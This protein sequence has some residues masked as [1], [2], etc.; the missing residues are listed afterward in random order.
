MA[1]DLCDCTGSARLYRPKNRFS[2]VGLPT[3]LQAIARALAQTP[4]AREHISLHAGDGA[5][6][7]ARGAKSRCGPSP[8]VTPT[9]S[10]TASS[11]SHCW[12][13]TSAAADA[14]SLEHAGVRACTTTTEESRGTIRRAQESGRPPPIALAQV[15]VRSGTVLPR[16]HR[17]EHQTAGAVPEHASYRPRDDGYR[18]GRGST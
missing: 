7:E 1:P 10:K 16:S 17:P 6:L 11:A 5:P 9:S 4:G 2:N 14:G 8:R 18:L 15:E 13:E 12:A 3:I